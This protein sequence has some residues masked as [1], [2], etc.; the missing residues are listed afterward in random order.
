[1][2]SPGAVGAISRANVAP[3]GRNSM[4]LS[5][6]GLRRPPGASL[7]VMHGAALWA[8]LGMIGRICGLLSRTD[9]TGPT[10]RTDQVD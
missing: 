8:E 6:P 3:S 5:Y 9:R 10:D 1:M 4:L 2:S 7:G